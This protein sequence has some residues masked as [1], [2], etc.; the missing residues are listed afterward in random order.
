MAQTKSAQPVKSKED[1]LT[2][3][4]E[5]ARQLALW[6][7]IENNLRL[8]TVKTFFPDE[9]ESADAKGTH[10]YELGDGAKLKAVFKQN[11]TIAKGDPLEAAL[12]KIEAT[13]ERGKL[14]AERVIK[15]EPKLD[16]KEYEAMP[17]DLRA[18][19][20]TVLTVKPGTP[21]LEIAIPK[22]I[23]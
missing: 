13:G 19:L 3:W 18:V 5:A 12:S 16:A 4:Q 15:W 20:D 17:D 9:A 1:L 2:E 6:K 11:V 22:S 8:L 21:S 14:I 7:E 23:R 10:N